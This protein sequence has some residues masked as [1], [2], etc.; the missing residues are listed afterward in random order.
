MTKNEIENDGL[1]KPKMMLFF[2]RYSQEEKKKSQ[3]IY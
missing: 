3:K 1:L 2:K